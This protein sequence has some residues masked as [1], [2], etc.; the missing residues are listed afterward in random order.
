MPKWGLCVKEK[1]AATYTREA[2]LRLRCFAG[3][4]LEERS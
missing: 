3:K 2:G 1:M 4:W